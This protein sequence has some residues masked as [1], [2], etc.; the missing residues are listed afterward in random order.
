MLISVAVV[1]FGVVLIFSGLLAY[2]G[3]WTGWAE[4]SSY[5]IYGGFAA[6]F[7]GL[8]FV[9]PYIHGA[10]VPKGS[11]WNGLMLP[12]AATL[13]GISVIGFWWMPSFMLPNWFIQGREERRRA[14]RASRELRKWLES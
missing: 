9:F 5:L 14:E 6:L 13:W 12:V 2:L 8:A 4:S 3:K 10:L 7:F 11:P 1:F